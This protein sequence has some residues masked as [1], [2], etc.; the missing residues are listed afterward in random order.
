MN[1]VVA[2]ELVQVEPRSLDAVWRAAAALKPKRIDIES[3]A[4][5]S[6]GKYSTVT[7]NFDVP[8]SESTLRIVGKHADISLAFEDAI[9]QAWRFGIRSLA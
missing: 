1:A 6:M 2:A 9:A 3:P 5:F 4:I 7:L 8:G